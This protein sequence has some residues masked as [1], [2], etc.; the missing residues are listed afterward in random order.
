MGR[1]SR[2]PATDGAC[3]GDWDFR[4]SDRRPADGS[5]ARKPRGMGQAQAPEEMSQGA[6]FQLQP[7]R[8]TAA[9]ERSPGRPRTSQVEEEDP[10]RTALWRSP[11]LLAFL[12]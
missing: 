5:A 11:L 12:L 2:S 7:Q 1:A 3:R 6:W 4:R 9:E 8:H 10:E